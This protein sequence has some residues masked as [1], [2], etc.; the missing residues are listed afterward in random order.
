MSTTTTTGRVNNITLFG[1]PLSIFPQT[2]Q[3]VFLFLSST[4]TFSI[5][6]V[7]STIEISSEDISTVNLTQNLFVSI[8]ALLINF[9][10][11]SVKRKCPLSQYLLLSI[12]F[13]AESICA[14][15]LQTI[16]TFEVLLFTKLLKALFLKFYIPKSSLCCNIFSILTLSLIFYFFDKNPIIVSFLLQ[17]VSSILFYKILSQIEAKYS[18][19]IYEIILYNFSLSLLISLPVCIIQTY[20]VNNMFT[21]QW[22]PILIGYSHSNIIF[23]KTAIFLTALKIF[24]INSLINFKLLETVLFI[25]IKCIESGHLYI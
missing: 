23:V 20:F 1:F 15:R 21:F 4:V 18:P 19:Q 22:H 25:V 2:I 5:Q 17:T 8:F 10:R 16:L 24:G 9:V 13:V 3:Y 6:T 14:L 11:P 7:I 12:C